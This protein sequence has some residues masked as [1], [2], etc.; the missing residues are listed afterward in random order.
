MHNTK[1]K[2]ANK[3]IYKLQVCTH[4]NA[5]K[6]RKV[7]EIHVHLCIVHDA[8]KEHNELCTMSKLSSEHACNIDVKFTHNAQKTLPSSPTM[9]FGKL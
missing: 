6:E 7:V 2:F 9:F 1:A 8:L 4:S 5:L 3:K